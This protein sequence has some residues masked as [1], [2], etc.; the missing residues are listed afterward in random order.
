MQVENDINW[1][2]PVGDDVFSF[3]AYHPPEEKLISN[4]QEAENRQR[5]FQRIPTGVVDRH[6]SKRLQ[7]YH[8]LVY[9]LPSASHAPGHLMPLLP[10]IAAGDYGLQLR[11][12]HCGTHTFQGMFGIGEHAPRADFSDEV[13]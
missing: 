7:D 13:Q 4:L 5:P 10:A 1:T 9:P 8:G 6:L 3:V 2:I 11:Q 12:V